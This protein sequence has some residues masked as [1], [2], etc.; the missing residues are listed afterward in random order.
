MLEQTSLLLL[1]WDGTP[2]RRARCIL[3]AGTRAPLG[4]ARSCP[5]AQFWS[6]WLGLPSLEVCETADLALLCQVHRPWPRPARWSVTDAD[7]QLVG[8]LHGG[9]V[10]DRLGQTVAVRAPL[11]GGA[12][13][14]FVS[15]AGVELGVLEPG[16]EGLRLSFAVWLEGEPFARMLLLAAAVTSD[17]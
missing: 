3:D 6:R 12:G 17:W 4:L 7:G 16:E 11:A 8:R 13:E 15:P 14:R 9:D 5:P 1:P 2:P 10:T